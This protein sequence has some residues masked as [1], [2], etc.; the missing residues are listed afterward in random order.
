MNNIP[1]NTDPVLAHPCGWWPED[2]SAE[3][4][5]GEEDSEDGAR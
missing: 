4:M 3:L 1:Q 2:E 5:D